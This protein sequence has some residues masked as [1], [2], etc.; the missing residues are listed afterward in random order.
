MNNNSTCLPA[1]CLKFNVWHFA[2]IR[3]LKILDGQ[4]SSYSKPDHWGYK[5]HTTWD[6][7]RAYKV[8]GRKHAFV[9]NSKLS[10]SSLHFFYFPFKRILNIC[11]YKSIFYRLILPSP[12]PWNKTSGA[13]ML[14]NLFMINWDKYGG[15]ITH[16]SHVL[17]PKGIC[18]KYAVTLWMCE[19]SGVLSP[20]EYAAHEGIF[21]SHYIIPFF[22][23]CP[24]GSLITRGMFSKLTLHRHF[25]SLEPVRRSGRLTQ[26]SHEK[27]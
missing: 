14:K 9:A 8:Q 13:R 27:L 24:F 16:L 11:R 2:S 18:Q 10:L 5:T 3:L 26:K 25:K 23:S 12:P 15:F 19:V 1:W 6:K 4:R 21:R 17:N 20:W 7:L 22:P